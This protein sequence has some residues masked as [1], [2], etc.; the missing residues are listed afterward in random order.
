MITTRAPDGA[1]NNLTFMIKSL[2][3]TPTLDTK[4][5]N[6]SLIIIEAASGFA[7]RR[8]KKLESWGWSFYLFTEVCSRVANLRPKTG[9]GKNRWATKCPWKCKKNPLDW[10]LFKS[11]RQ[12]WRELDIWTKLLSNSSHSGNR[13]SLVHKL[14]KKKQKFHFW[15]FPQAKLG[16]CRELWLKD[17]WQDKP[18]LKKNPNG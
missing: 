15:I 1:N 5:K 11:G 14:L 6:T 3:S 4:S 17:K 12:A 13:C 8:M 16:L 2:P 9:L 7:K 18:S 10:A